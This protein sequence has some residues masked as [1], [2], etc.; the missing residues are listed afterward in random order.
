MKNL[1]L[2]LWTTN[3][4]ILFY[5]FTDANYILSQTIK[6][7]IQK[8]EN[9]EYFFRERFYSNNKEAYNINSIYQLSNGN[10]VSCNTNGIKIYYE[11]N[12]KYELELNYIMDIEVINAIEIKINQLILFQANFVSGGFCSQSYHCTLTY[13]VSLYDIENR[14][15]ICLN[16]FKENVALRNNKINFFKSNELLFVKFG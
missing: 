5:K 2:A 1:D 7:S 8:E 16:E 6:E 13:S 11:K 3:A 4:T 10:I 14:K 15:S 9:K 12:K